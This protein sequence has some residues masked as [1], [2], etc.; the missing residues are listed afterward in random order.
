M[1]SIEQCCFRWHIQCVVT[2][3]RWWV[4][5][6]DDN[7]DY[8]V[9]A[10][11]TTRLDGTLSFKQINVYRKYGV[12][13]QLWRLGLDQNAVSHHITCLQQLGHDLVLTLTLSYRVKMVL[14]LRVDCNAAAWSL[15]LTSRCLDCVMTSPGHTQLHTWHVTWH[16][17]SQRGRSVQARYTFDVFLISSYYILFSPFLLLNSHS[18]HFSTICTFFE[19]PFKVSTITKSK[20]AKINFVD[21]PT[22][23]WCLSPANQHKPYINRNFS[24]WAT[25]LP[26]IIWVY[27]H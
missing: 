11:F 2:Y 9:Q 7:D 15:A 23:I 13:R 12:S 26:L 10:V 20:E 5:D 1:C 16:I 25:Y 14:K 27:L 17:T 4:D 24:L 22:L 3:K 18:S 6:D 19:R 21:D 8:V